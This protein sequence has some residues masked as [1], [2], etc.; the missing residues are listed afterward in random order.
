[1]FDMIEEDNIHL[2]IGCDLV[3][4][5]GKDEEDEVT[6]TYYFANHSTRTL[7]WLC[8]HDISEFMHQEVKA[9]RSMAHLGL[10]IETMYW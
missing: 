8:Q 1:M 4:E 3:L 7:F 10:E 5:L 9:V 6:W 2:P